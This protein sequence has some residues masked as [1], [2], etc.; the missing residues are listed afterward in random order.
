ML[1]PSPSNGRTSATA[2]ARATSGGTLR[3]VD[4]LLPKLVF[5]PAL[6]TFAT[7]VGR[8]FGQSIA[9]WLIAFPFNSAPVSIFLAI[10]HGERFAADAARG[11]IASVAGGCAYAVVFARVGRGWPVALVSA[12]AAYL[13]VAGAMR[14]VTLDAIPL[15][16]LMCAALLAARWLIPAPGDRAAVLR[17]T[18]RWDL[19]ARIVVATSLVV[20]ITIFAPTLGAYGS[21][22]A[23]SFP[24]FASILGVF[25]E[26]TEGHAAAVAVMRGLVSGLFGFIAF[27]VVVALAIETLHVAFTFALATLAVLAVQGVALA[28][29]RR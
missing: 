17:V 12:S 28:L 3:S 14:L 4:T 24:V 29:L 21:A 1:L 26:R 10:D 18:P 23:A 15:A 22:I 6:I 7:L 11:S 9:G 13:A 5:T 25:E 2:P 16:I 8:R 27:F 20:G 19:P